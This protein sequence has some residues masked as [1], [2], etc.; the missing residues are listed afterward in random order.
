MKVIILAGGFGTRLSEY[1]DLVPKPM[2]RIGDRPILWHIM[3]IYAAYGFNEF[4]I[5]LG[6]KGEYIK[7]YFLN[8]HHLQSDLTVE[9]KTGK[10][11][12][13]KK[14]FRDWVIKLVD[15]GKNTMT[16]GRL[17]RLQEHLKNEPF[18]LTYGDGLCNINIKKLLQFHQNHQKIATVTAVRP[19][20]RFGEMQFNDNKVTAFKEKPQTGEGW[21]NG[22][23]FIFQPEIFD[24]LQGDNTVLE[25]SPMEILTKNGALMAYKHTDFWQ[26]MDTLRDKN[27][28]ES[29]WQQ[30]N[31]PWKIW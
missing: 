26:C 25:G 1:T 9:L 12:V 11:T 28:L 4:I 8:Y 20:A 14:H 6:Y 30:D 31:P 23:F 24:Y 3:N 2:V 5:A 7:D 17:H 16:G 29:L 18:L 19:T 21:I 22:G 15:T 13:A 27:M 10:V